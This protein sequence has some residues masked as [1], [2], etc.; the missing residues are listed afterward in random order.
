MNTGPVLQQLHWLPVKHCLKCKVLLL[1]FK[2][3]LRINTPIP[4][5]LP[6]GSSSYSSG[7]H[8]TLEAQILQL[9]THNSPLQTDMLTHSNKFGLK[10]CAHWLCSLSLTCTTCCYLLQ[11]AHYRPSEPLLLPADGGVDAHHRPLLHSQASLTGS[12]VF[13]PRLFAPLLLCYE[14]PRGASLPAYSHAAGPWH[15]LGGI[16]NSI[17]C[18]R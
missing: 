11:V 7:T 1:T 14:H 8:N 6:C 10:I 13:C 2:N 17:F 18:A 3:L 5:V 16:W 12:A 9:T 15:L 4:G